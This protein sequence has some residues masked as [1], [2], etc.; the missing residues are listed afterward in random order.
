M[1]V[2][3]LSIPYFL[4]LLF[5]IEDTHIPRNVKL[6]IITRCVSRIIIES[7]IFSDDETACILEPLQLEWMENTNIYRVVL[8]F[9]KQLLYEP[10]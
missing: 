8:D 3:N 6:F 4:G 5:E 9:S 2:T 7:V 1:N 10:I